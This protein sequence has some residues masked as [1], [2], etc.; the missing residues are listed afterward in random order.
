MTVEAL[1][2][3]AGDNPELDEVLERVNQASGYDFRQYKPGTVIRR[4]E[5]RLKAFGLADYRAYLR[6]LEANPDEYHRLAEDITIKTSQFFRYPHTYTRL[7]D[8]VLPTLLAL[9]R[10]SGQ[11]QI[12]FWSAACAQGEEPYSLAM[13]LDDYCARRAPNMNVCIRATDISQIA[14]LK[15]LS[16]IYAPAAVTNVPDGFRKQYLQRVDGH[17]E[18]NS[19]IRGLVRFSVLDL[20][21]LETAPWSDVDCVFCCNVLIYLKRKLQ[22]RVL[23]SL[24]ASLATP[25]FL[26]LGEV[27][28]LPERLRQRMKCL[29]ARARIYVK[30]GKRQAPTEQGRL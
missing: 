20:A 1:K 12:T 18:V 7:T 28:T 17:Y 14:L 3:K 16:G 11:G 30:T 22:E 2:Q 10:A 15:A 6:Y 9:K 5:R 8:I 25:G 27:E 23:E 24:Y 4:V 19:G 21:K 26:V 13:L 29:D